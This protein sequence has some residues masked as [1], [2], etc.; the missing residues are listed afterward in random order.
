MEARTSAIA[1]SAHSFMTLVSELQ[2][3]FETQ[4]DGASSGV[5]AR[6]QFVAIVFLAS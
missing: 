3:L 2:S 4:R 1:G 5:Q 6:N